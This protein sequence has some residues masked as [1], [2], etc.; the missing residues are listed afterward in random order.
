V[1]WLAAHQPA[2]AIVLACAALLWQVIQFVVTH[3]ND[4]RNRQFEAY[5][6]LIK[7]LVK[8]E[9]GQTHIDRQ[10][11]VVFELVRFKRY[12]PLTIR[13]LRGLQDDWKNNP[14]F[15]PRLASEIDRALRL[16]E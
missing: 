16:M 11:A 14:N 4:A 7:E 8:P 2:I 12:R 15:H 13:I 5:H 6:R 1:S 10:C 3:T 9:N